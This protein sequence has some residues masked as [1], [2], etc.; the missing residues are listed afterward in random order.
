MISVSAMSAHKRHLVRSEVNVALYWRNIKKECYK[1]QTVNGDED[2]RR[3]S[4][5]EGPPGAEREGAKH[6][7][8]D[9]SMR[10]EIPSKIYI[11]K[12][13]FHHLNNS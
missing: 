6:A 3:V 9:I 2:A 12:L 5:I 1:G 10:A 8:F 4:S 7:A 13:H 11:E